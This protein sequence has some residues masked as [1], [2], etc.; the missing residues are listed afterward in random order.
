MSFVFHSLGGFLAIRSFLHLTRARIQNTMKKLIYAFVILLI[1][2]SLVGQD[3]VELRSDG[4]VL[5]SLTSFERDKIGSPENGHIIYNETLDQVEV[6]QD[7]AWVHLST[8][9]SFSWKIED[10]ED[11]N[12]G[13]YAIDGSDDFVQLVI[14]GNSS[15]YFRRSPSGD[16]RIDLENSVL[17]ENTFLGT[18]AGMLNDST[19][20]TFI[21]FRAGSSNVEGS[22]NTFIGSYA[23][24]QN[25]GLNDS[26]VFMGYESGRNT[27][28]GSASNNVAIGNASA[29]YLNEG[30]NVMIG[31]EAGQNVDQQLGGGLNATRD[32]VIIGYQAGKKNTGCC[33]T[34][35][36]HR[37]GSNNKGVGNV[38][39]GN[40]SGET[41]TGTS[42]KLYIHNSSATTPLIYGDF[43]SSR[44]G[45]NNDNPNYALDVNGIIEGTLILCNGVSACSDNRL[46]K[47]FEK[48]SN[49]LS[50][51]KQLDGYYHDWRVEEFKEFGFSN[52]RQ[53]GFVAQDVEK[54]F[55]ELIEVRDDGYLTVD[56]SKMT[57]VLLQAIK[58][59]QVLIDNQ[60]QMFEKLAGESASREA[61]LQ[62]LEA[63]L[64]TITGMVSE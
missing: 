64:T 57:A 38:F 20:N 29:Q 47:N 36:G 2:F 28:S 15:L 34:Y 5:P 63:A 39:I 24:E 18:D 22:K 42:N 1:P 35:I 31:Y 60:Q 56:Y 50:K 32:N 43:S 12:T 27:I 58:E 40:N 7:G 44:V 26:N 13:V 51:V 11:Q 46:K 10:I 52:R 9:S 49:V 37:S 19:A 62:K 4:I 45:I 53:I 16:I 23:G 17:T 6:Q 48:L 3:E 59:Q 8:G 30:N 25:G 61:R 14:D 55:P 41:L 21:G 33:N 54:F